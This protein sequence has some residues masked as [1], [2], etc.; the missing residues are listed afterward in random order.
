M[1]F[2]HLSDLHFGKINGS[3]IE[4]FSDFVKKSPEKIDGILVTGDL[5]QRA[6]SQQFI[7][8]VKFIEGLEFPIAVTVPGNHDVPLYNLFLRIFRPYAKY[9]KFVTLSPTYFDEQ[10]C[11]F[12]MRTVNPWVV[13]E[14]K[15]FQEE[16]EQ[17]EEFFNK[18][19]KD[20]QTRILLS[21]HSV[22]KLALKSKRQD[23]LLQRISNLELDL[24]LC[25]HDHQTS[26]EYLEHK[27]KTPVIT[28]GTGTS[29][30]LRGEENQFNLIE[31]HEGKIQVFSLTIDPE[32]QQ[33]LSQHLWVSKP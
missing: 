10:M 13:Q 22:K 33:F 6:R 8:A 19:A 27:K 28:A 31:I 23:H 4:I 24:I 7:E 25:G 5:T 2:I 18:N 29:S 3:V 20:G 16:V 32:K 12:G 21:H 30:R 11:I 26:V 1:R 17:A 14:G 9:N 15:I